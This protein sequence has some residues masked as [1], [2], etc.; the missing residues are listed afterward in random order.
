MPTTVNETET[1]YDVPAGA[2]M[3]RLD[4]LPR[5]ADTRGPEEEL[6]A[7]DQRLRGDGLRRCGRSARLQRALSDQLGD[8]SRPPR[9]TARSSAGE[10]V[11]GYLREQA[12]ALKALDPMVRR[13]QPDS[14]HQMRVATRRLRCTLRSFSAVI[15]RSGTERLDAELRWLGG[16]LGEARDAEVLAQH[17]RG[18]LQ[19]LP[20]EQRIGPVQARIQGHFAGIAADARAAVLEALDSE[21]YLSLLD[22]LDRVLADPPLDPEAS[23]A[24]GDVL[25]EQVR[26]SY[27]RARRGMRRAWREPDGQARDVALHEARKAVKRARYAGEAVAPV[28]G[29]Q[30]RRFT[31]Q[32]KKIH[33]VL[34]DHQDAVIARRV[35]RELGI[36]A[37]LAGENA[38]SYGLLHERDT[39]DARRLQ[40][41]ARR[42]WKRASRR[43]YRR[44]MP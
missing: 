21:R 1:K 15:S 24:A 4:N 11:L 34:G 27:R 9:L 36:G 38:F 42:L 10:V 44:W 32:M 31:K 12:A 37:H 2:A 5:V 20:V 8:P 26:R 3:P 19:G 13:D 28:F 14:V 25:P 16:V 39:D 7:A 43:R 17:L 41:A 33:S 6:L 30:A 29:K 22:E 23:L 18:G 40:V 35:E